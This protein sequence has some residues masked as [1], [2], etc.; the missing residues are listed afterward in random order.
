MRLIHKKIGIWDET[1]NKVLVFSSINDGVD[2][3]AAFYITNDREDL[4]I[5]DGQ[6]ILNDVTPTLDGR[7]LQT[8]ATDLADLETIVDSK[9]KVHVILLG[10][11]GCVQFSDKEV[12]SS[13]IYLTAN[14]QLSGNNVLAI[15]GAKIATAS[16]FDAN[17][18]KSN[19]FNAHENL[20]ATVKWIEG[21]GGLAKNWNQSVAVTIATF[22]TGEQFLEFG[23]GAEFYRDVFFPFEGED[24]TFSLGLVSTGANYDGDNSEIKIEWYDKSDTLLTTSTGSQPIGVTAGRKSVTGT[25]PVGTAYARCLIDLAVTSGAGEITVD[26]PALT[27][28]NSTTFTQ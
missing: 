17:G 22:A 12:A 21:T 7:F 14:E 9:I 8:D 4:T 25:A 19:Y 24:L 20:F 10:I 26:D 2:G 16:Y 27:I 23:D 13:K 15:M 3:S 18:I 11:D 1:N 28:N 6:L 5:E